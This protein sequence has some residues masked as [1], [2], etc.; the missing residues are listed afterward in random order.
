MIFLTEGK[1]VFHVSILSLVHLG[2]RYA[3]YRISCAQAFTYRPFLTY[4]VTFVVFVCPYIRTTL[5]HL[6]TTVRFGGIATIWI[7]VI[8]IIWIGVSASL[9]HSC[10]ILWSIL[11]RTFS[12]YRYIAQI[13]LWW[14]GWWCFSFPVSNKRKCL[15]VLSFPSSNKI[16][17]SLPWT[18]LSN[19]SGDN[20][21]DRVVVCFEWGW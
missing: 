15:F 6:F 8:V 10:T 18:F 14:C 21:F 17:C 2:N 11:N 20:A 7:G 4:Y 19:C 3:S 13:S 5:A 9:H 1:K 12:I 16:A